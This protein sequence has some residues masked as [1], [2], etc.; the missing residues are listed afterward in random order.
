[1]SSS[2]PRALQLLTLVSAVMAVM[3]LAMVFLYAP[4]EVSMGEVQRI[5]YFHVSSAWVGGV[6]LLVAL[7][8]GI[9][10][11]VTGQPKWD[12]LEL[13]SI[14]VGLAFSVMVLFTGMIWGRPAWNTWWTWDPRTTTFAILILIYFAYLML[15]QSLE[16]PQRRARFAAVYA[17][18]AFVSVPITFFAIRLWRTIHPVVIGSSDPSAQ[19]SFNMVPPMVQT[20]LF[21]ILFFTV[22]YLTLLW[23]RLRLAE[24]EE[25][26]EALKAQAAAA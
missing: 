20:L 18:L 21:C 22:L 12:R 7:V 5:F 17:I 11:L 1:M 23:H 24:Q 14:E 19:G 4:R 10:V 13:A 26:I 16:D 2:T 6:A 3:A 9:L 15:R 8:A 25:K